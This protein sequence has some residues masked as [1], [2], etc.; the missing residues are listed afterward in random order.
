[1][2][3]RVLIDIKNQ[4]WSDQKT[5]PTFAAARHHRTL[6]AQRWND[7]ATC[8]DAPDGRTLA[9]QESLLYQAELKK[10]LAEA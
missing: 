10:I 7:C 2:P 8:I 5:F 3:Y 6:V 4:W 9:W 1:M